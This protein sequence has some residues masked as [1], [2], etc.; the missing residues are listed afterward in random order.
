LTAYARERGVLA[1]TIL[2]AE[3]RIANYLEHR[4]DLIQDDHETHR[5][6]ME[7]RRHQREL[8]RR[9]RE[10]TLRALDGADARGAMERGYDD[11]VVEEAKKAALAQAKWERTRAEWG[12]EAFA[13]SMPLRK[14]RLEH[15]YKT[16]A[17]D[18][19]I[20]ALIRE[21]SRDEQRHSNVSQGSTGS[22]DAVAT[23][24]QLLA[25]LNQEIENA[26][27]THASDDELA[28]LY[29]FRSRLNARLKG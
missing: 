15:L 4:D 21:G 9:R 1:D 12:L 26:H 18:A 20:D 23:I 19:E 13:Q 22:S 3:R 11:Q 8:N 24:E 29:A 27:A 7:E 6:E 28:V 10:Q 2:D 14:E 16:G 17:L 5:D 25:E